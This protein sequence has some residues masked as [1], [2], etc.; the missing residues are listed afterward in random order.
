ML[1]A[2]SEIGDFVRF[3]GASK[4]PAVVAIELICSGVLARSTSVL[5]L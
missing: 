1:A 2:A 3:L 5:D 4:R